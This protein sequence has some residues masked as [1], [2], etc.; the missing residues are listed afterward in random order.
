MRNIVIIGGMAAGC[1]AAARLSRLSSENR[2]TIIEKSPFVSLSRCGLPQ[3]ISGDLD[4]V[5]ELTKTPYG[6]KR[7]VN[8]FREF[9]GINVL[10][11]TEATDIDPWKKEVACIDHKNKDNVRIK[12]DELILATGCKN[13]EPVFPYVPSD[14]ITF[15]HSVS[16]ILEF[17][18]K[19]QKGLIKKAVIIGGGIKGLETAESLISL[20][21]IETILIEKENQI[22]NSTLDYE[23]SRY[24]EGCI[25]PGKILMLLSTSVEKIEKDKNE[26]PVIYLDNGQKIVADSV[27]LCTGL[28][29][30]T[31]I[32]ERINIKIGSSGG[33]IVDNQ[34]RTSIPEIWAAGDCIEIKNILTD[35]PGHY[36]GGSNS[37]RLGRAAADSLSGEKVLFKGTVTTDS[38]KIFD[39][40]ICTAGLTEKSAVDAGFA[41]GSVTGVWSDRADFHPDV[42]NI[43][44]K[45]VYQKPGLKLL[46]LQLIGKG[47]I[48]RYIDV[49]C[50][51][52]RE[53]RTVKSL[54]CIEHAFN[55]SHSSP[56]TPLNYL[57]FMAINQEKDGV[58]NYNPLYL[59]SFTG[60]FVDVR[61]KQDSESKP[62]PVHSLNIPFS[63][64]RK[65]LNEFETKQEIIFICTK[66]GRSY[67]TARHF[68]NKGFKNVAYLGG[69]SL[70]LNALK[71]EPKLEELMS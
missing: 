65:R 17:R 15:L 67:E 34:M 26:L 7:D 59:S 56:F 21:G 55:P 69:G 35:T 29:P 47:E 10:L 32:A 41:T 61:E 18:E 49:F 8:F 57:G 63:E 14:R 30:D 70:L 28:V 20:W 12:Y 44:G 4:N 51:L 38:V 43:I 48:A 5:Y 62:L 27:I 31:E 39:Y 9:E 42:N 64:I 23:I 1:K 71:D 3:F 25:N 46:G 58:M 60:M 33:I 45:L 53:R 40:N 19:L 2:I 13:A 37:N 24:L 68:A 16:G 36:P 66:G 6:I 50:E 11:N 22:L 52:L 54:L